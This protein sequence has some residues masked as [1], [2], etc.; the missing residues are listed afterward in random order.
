MPV[1][2]SSDLAKTLFGG[3]SMGRYVT[4]NFRAEIA[5]E[6]Y[7][8]VKV[9]GP[10]EEHYTDAQPIEGTT[11]VGHY[12]V[13]RA[14]TVRVGR[15]TG[16]FNLYYDIPVSERFKP[17]IGAGIGLTWRSMKRK[18]S[19][20]AEC[21]SSTDAADPTYNSDACA[22]VPSDKLSYT[23]PETKWEVDRFDLALA[24]MAGISY[25]ITD[26]IIW[27]NGYQL[28]WENGDVQLT[29]PTHAGAFS[30]VTYGGALQHQFRT[31]LRFVI[32]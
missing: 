31:G 32:D 5:V 17:Y 26:D 3:I 18:A 2:D 25:A 4:P 27:D 16:M 29:S 15:T 19:E 13:T 23:L 11:Y 8:S 9:A 6:A 12:D 20:H 22:G 24:A 7:G 1:R 30:T 10:A 21:T 14:D 28:L